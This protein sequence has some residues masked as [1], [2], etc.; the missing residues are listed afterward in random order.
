MKW[1]DTTDIKNWATRRDCQETLPQL[2][3][4]LIRA[5]SHSIK[6]IKF[7]SGENV[8]IGGW[9]GILEVTEQTEYLPLGISVWEFGSDKDIKGK[10]DREYEKRSK[11]P[12]GFNPTECVFIFVTPRLWTKS[13]EWV[14]EKKKDGIWKDV[15]VINAETLDEWLEI[16]PTVSSWLAIKHIGKYPSEGIQSTEDFWSEWTSGPKFNLNSDVLLGGRKEQIEKIFELA[17]NPTLIAVQGASR[18]EAL[19]FVISCFKND[20]DKEEDFFAR[21][22]IVDSADTFRRLSVLKNPLIFVPRFDDTGILNRAT[23]NGHCVIVPLGADSSINWSNKI[24]LPQIDREAFVEAL[25]KTGITKELAEKYSKESAR[26]ITILRRQLEFVRIVPEWAKVENVRD[27]IPAL[28]VGRWNENYK[29]DQN[30][31][32]KLSGENYEGYSKKLNLWLYSSDSPFVKIGTSWRLASPLDAWSNASKYLTPHDF[33]LLHTSFIEI[34]NEIDPAFELEPEKRYMASIYDKNRR[35][36]SWIREGITQSLILVSIYGNQLKFN[37]SIK[38]ESWVD[39]IIAELLNTDDPLLWKSIQEMLPLISEAS[40]NEFLNAVEKYLLL[41]KSP[42]AALFEEDPG[43]ISPQSYHTGLLWALESLAWLPEYLSRASLVLARLSAIDPGG[44]LSNRPINS[45]VDIFKPWHY[46]TLSP[47]EER[48]EVLKLIAKKKREVAWTLLIRM[49]PE[50]HSIGNFTHKMR[51]RVFGLSFEKSYTY[52]EIWNT[53]TAVVDLLLTIFDFSET[54]LSAL[55]EK[56]TKLSSND[57]DKLLSFIESNLDKVKQI[58]FS[59]WHTLRNILSDHRSYP[60][61]D[62][63]LREP[64]LSRYEKL[65]A[66]L[67]PSDEIQK[68]TWMFNDYWPRFPEG[69]QYKKISHEEH[70]RNVHERRIES[71]KNIYN[72]YGIKKIVEL[73]LTVKLPRVLGNTFGY[74]VENESEILSLCDELNKEKNYWGF[75]HFLIF[76]KSMS[77]GLDWTFALY[78]KLREK[79]FNNIALAQV[80]VPLNPTKELWD[81]IDSTNDEIKKE[82]WSTVDPNFWNIPTDQKVIGLNCLIKYKRYVSAI[83]VCCHFVED[84]PTNT[85]VEILEKA[86]TEK[87][88]EN[89]HLQGYEVEQLF[90]SLSK[91]N[92]VDKQ[93]LIKLEWYYLPL[94]ASYDNNR[95]LKLLHEELS[96]NPDFFIDALKCMYKPHNDEILEAETHELSNE[97][98]QNRAEKAFELLHSWDI[99]PGVDGKGNID[100]EFLWSWINKVREL[101]VKNHRI[102]VADMHIGRLLAQYPENIASWPP[103][104]ICNVIE[105]INTE[106]IKRGFYSATWEKRSSSTRGPFD[107]GDIERGHEKY[108]EGL[109]NI[110]KNK[111]PNTAT[112]LNN[113][114]KG[115]EADA[116]R[117]DDKAEK[118]KL[119]Y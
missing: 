22:V 37:L 32:A 10:A 94:L 27:I 63:A 95:N 106:D 13:D 47:F 59:S 105:V 16:A 87:S 98:I 82:Y 113:L 81:F 76:R 38:G 60:D 116:K 49:L 97:Q 43:F 102:E 66:L 119:E 80:F 6:S 53:H 68:S 35:F 55:I 83:D 118:D 23:A 115:Y 77:K 52:Q 21:S 84:I 4:K 24:I 54:K 58:D 65:Y 15:K 86:A 18:E 90:K 39:R 91:R 36:S 28:I 93:T 41:D 20:S 69:H 14:K 8:L 64:E 73:S 100:A 109:S 71:I 46:Q 17:S 12:L 29:N 99:I 57:R 5:T 74:I 30:I 26:N 89:V 45:L 104:E 85:I 31:L 92:N 2:V 42:I 88:I 70:E 103:D 75:I 72:K 108:F 44:R 107:G 34:L 114:A 50:G 3:R 62:W 1:I 112:I 110:H 51:W 48:I 117:M 25:T 11:N 96:N 79:G 56:S 78:G 61:A 33:E 7:P 19:A 101:A 67:E 40:P 9:D 111:F